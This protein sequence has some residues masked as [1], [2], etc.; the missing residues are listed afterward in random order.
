MLCLKCQYCGDKLS[1]PLPN[2]L[3]Y[4]DEKEPFKKHH[5]C[6]CGDCDFYEKDV[7]NLG[8]T[9]CEHFEEL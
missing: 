9:S 4:A 1:F 8:I 6:C 2:N 3:I 7:T 5:Y